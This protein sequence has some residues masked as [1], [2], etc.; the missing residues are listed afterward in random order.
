V[1][2]PA[3]AVVEGPTCF[4]RDCLRDL[5]FATK[6]CGDCGSPRLARH[7]ALP[8]LTLAHIDCDAFYATVEKR[9]NPELA[10]KPVIIGGGKRGVVAAACY[11][12]RTFGVRSAMP[13]FKALALCPSATVIRPDM[14]KYVR[15]G[16]E[17]RRAM[18]AL[19]PLVEP[20]SIDEAFLDLEGTQR[21]H[22]LIPAKVLARFA[23]DVE[24]DIGITVSV[25]LSCN[26]FLAKVASDLDKPRGFASLDQEEA[27]V[28]LADKP[29]G[30]IFGVGPATQER[31]VQR[32]FRT[33]ADLQRAE[34]N[35]LIKQFGAE[36]RRLW[37]L[38][39]GHDDRRVVPDRGAKTISSE[40]TFDNDIRDFATLEKTLWRLS[41]RV[42]ARLKGSELAGS[43][44]TLKLKTAD[45]RQR[46]R[47]QSIHAPTQLAARIFAVSRQM[48]AKEID[49]TAFRLMGAGVSALRPGSDAHDTDMLDRRFADA[50]RAID[51]LRKKFGQAAVIRGIAYEGPEQSEAAGDEE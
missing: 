42:S 13:M 27:C 2:S 21:V 45:F 39:R 44:I 43:T 36:G 7:R 34:E 19:T 10:D 26:K 50:E 17:V 25:G 31:L 18:Q 11:I 47:S 49:G 5:E 35:D 3:P 33:V 51:N 4:C 40:T 15:V 32:G 12:S 16:R 29:V 24:R 22:E 14:A 1:S 46:T 38:A 37:Q 6:R 8:S 28:M 48:L 20:L 23:R 41:E 9:D 30:F